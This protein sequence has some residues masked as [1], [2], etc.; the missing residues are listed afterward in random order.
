MEFLLENWYIGI[1]LVAVLF[2]LGLTV[3]LFFKQPSSKQIEKIK[4]WLIYTVVA[5][6]K[7]LGSKTGKLKL[8]LVYGAF[9]SKFKWA[10]MIISFETFSLLVDSALEEMRV[11]LETNKAVV[12]LVEG[13]TKE[14]S[15]I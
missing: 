15:D 14:K 5:A 2:I 12:Q 7:E 11:M 10:S 6:E 3:Y 1:A 8:S 4:Q 9:I 13:E